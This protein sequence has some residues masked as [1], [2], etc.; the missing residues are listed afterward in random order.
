MHLKNAPLTYLYDGTLAGF[1]CCVYESVYAR[2][3]PLSIQ[4]AGEEAQPGF[5][6]KKTI[7]TDT[8]KALRVRNSVREKISLAALDMAEHAFLS[9]MR[10]K[11]LHILRF[12]L[13]GYQAGGKITSQLTHRDVAPLIQANRHLFGEQHLLLGFLRFTDYDGLLVAVI[14][15]KNFVLPLM[16]DHFTD[17]YSTEKFLIY[18][19]T[20]CA[21]LVFDGVRAEIVRMEDLSLRPPDEAEERYRALWKQFYHTIAIK[22]RTNPVCRRSHMP[23]RYWENMLEVADELPE[24]KK[25]LKSGAEQIAAVAPLPMR[26]CGSSP[27]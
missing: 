5:F 7:N 9:C 19:K 27:Q 2:E 15:P 16:T 24:K 25:C 21:A 4:S 13:A 17:R 1:Y 12:L 20:H 6:E 23:M 3:M 14:T 18:D 22:E 26:D 11:E 10:E 8:Q